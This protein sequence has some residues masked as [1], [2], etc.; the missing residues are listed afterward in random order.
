MLLRSIDLFSGVG[1]LTL[2]LR[3]VATPL[4]YCDSCPR[5]TAVLERHMRRG[6]LPSAPVCP[7][8]RKLDRGWLEANAIR[9][10]QV[11]MIVGGFPCVGFS[12]AGAQDGLKNPQSALFHELLRVA[13]ITGAR[14]LFLENVPQILNIGIMQIL[15]LLWKRGFSVRWCTVSACDVGAPQQRRRWYCLAVRGDPPKPSR[16]RPAASSAD[17]YRRFRWDDRTMP[18][19]A[20]VNGIHE[21][22]ATARVQL[23][24]NSVVPDAVRYAFGYLHSGCVEGTFTAPPPGA[25]P[26]PVD[27]A[28]GRAREVRSGDKAPSCGYA[29]PRRVYALAARPAPR[30]LR[31]SPIELLPDAYDSG[32]EPSPL[33]TSE[34]VTGPIKKRLWA[35]PSYSF[36]GAA[37]F[38]TTRNERH[39]QTQVRFERH[40][41]E[42]ARGKPINPRFV[43]W[44]MGFPPDWTRGGERTS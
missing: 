20:G 15:R 4:A 5:A 31:T 22:D 44:L 10:G 16:R 41:P 24:G 1:G 42:E 43:E 36:L 35:T 34:R 32:R 19:R 25:W 13:D 23:L 2:A 21:A 9:D 33:Q 28:A 39:L 40:T 38:L 27:V 26:A 3:G 29:P 30:G 18:Q 37:N 7:D 12:V 6:A 11:D 8:V 14:M 17:R